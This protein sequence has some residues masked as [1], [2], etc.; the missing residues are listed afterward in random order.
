MGVQ[1][2]IIKPGNGIDYPKKNDEVSMEYTGNTSVATCCSRSHK[3]QAGSL[4]TR[5]LVTRAQ[6]MIFFSPGSFE[7]VVLTEARFDTSIG[8]GDLITAIGVGRVIR[9]APS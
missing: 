6:S 1:K 3:Q 5:H 8:R 7:D 2:I 4:T 9:G